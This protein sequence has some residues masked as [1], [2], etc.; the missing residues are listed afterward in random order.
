MSAILS[1]F[2]TA[3]NKK[4]GIASI[5][6]ICKDDP[7][8]SWSKKTKSR[9]HLIDYELEL[10]KA[11]MISANQLSEVLNVSLFFVQSKIR[12]LVKKGRVKRIFIDRYCFFM[13]VDNEHI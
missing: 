12:E 11:K 8:E 7:V 1:A 5:V 10:K 13:H 4:I 2:N 9:R 3:P 6:H